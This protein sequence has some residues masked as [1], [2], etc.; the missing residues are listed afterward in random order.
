MGYLTPL[1]SIDNKTKRKKYCLSKNL[2]NML[3]IKMQ[4]GYWD[5]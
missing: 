3:I 2:V 5:L 1:E 4:I